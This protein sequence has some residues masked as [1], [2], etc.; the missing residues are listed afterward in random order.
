MSTIHTALLVSLIPWG[1][2][3]TDSY[4]KSYQFFKTAKA[5]IYALDSKTVERC[6]TELKRCPDFL[7]QLR[8]DS[9][10]LQMALKVQYADESI[11]SRP[12]ATIKAAAQC[13]MILSIFEKEF[14]IRREHDPSKGW[15]ECLHEYGK[16]VWHQ[17]KIFMRYPYCLLETH[18]LT[19]SKETYS[20]LIYPYPFARCLVQITLAAWAYENGSFAYYGTRL[21]QQKLET[22]AQ[23]IASIE[24]A[25]TA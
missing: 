8:S 19:D 15:L 23:I 11:K 22:I 17:L 3:A 25:A 18:Q 6:L 16:D 13:I 10:N 12:W 7:Q 2:C 4:L 14:L 9:L 20:R 5:A 1:L 24:S 21:T